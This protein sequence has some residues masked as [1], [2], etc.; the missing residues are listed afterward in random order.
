MAFLAIGLDSESGAVVMTTATG[1]ALFHLV[2]A[3]TFIT[4]SGGVE[5]RMTILATVG[6]DMRGMT[7]H[8][9][10][11]TEV[12]LFHNMALLTISLD[13]EGRLA[14]MTCAAGVSRFHRSHAVTL[15]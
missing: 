14:V 5:S 7:E 13:P 12:D 2:H 6:G 10:A 15:A 1:F 4:R 8:R 9:A 11:G 3:E